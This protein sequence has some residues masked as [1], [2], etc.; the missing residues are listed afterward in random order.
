MLPV[1]RK[2]TPRDIRRSDK[3]ADLQ[4]DIAA[5]MTTPADMDPLSD[6]DF[7]SACDIPG[8][9]DYKELPPEHIKSLAD[10]EQAATNNDLPAVEQS[11]DSLRRSHAS[12]RLL[13]KPGGALQIAVDKQH[14]DIVRYF[15]SQGAQVLSCHVKS[16]VLSHSKPMIQL[17]LDHGWPINAE[18]GWSDPPLLAYATD[19]LDLTTWLLSLGADP[20]AS[21]GLNKTPLSAAVQYSSLKV[22][23][24]LFAHGGSV[25]E[26]QL[27][28][29]AI[30]RERADR[31]AVT[32]YLLQQGAPV[33]AI[34]YHEHQ[35]SFIQ[36]EPFGIGTPLHDAAAVGD[37]EVIELLL[38]WGA[39]VLARDTRGRLPHER[40]RAKGHTV[41]AG[42]LLPS[43]SQNGE[44]VVEI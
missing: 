14:E 29:Y 26:G 11:F 8:L 13:A 23:E 28:H 5:L 9:F 4:L 16:A 32:E 37:I 3:E 1:L 25:R 38:D 6:F 15:L 24:L 18:L 35:E 39:D 41:A 40:A 31:V 22:I 21:C 33:N 36:R 27:L 44:F 42:R 2:T 43:L 7:D 12:A 34:M 17:L 30:W 20:N 19:N 10:L